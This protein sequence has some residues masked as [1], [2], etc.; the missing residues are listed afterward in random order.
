[1][2]ADHQT[3]NAE[4]FALGGAAVMVSDADLTPTRLRQEV[5]A[6]LADHERR[7]RMAVA[8]IRLARPDAASVIAGHLLELAP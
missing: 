4:H 1:V 3:R 7:E 2:T 6:L 8:A 5:N